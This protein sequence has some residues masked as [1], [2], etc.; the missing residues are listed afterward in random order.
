M[1]R[2]NFKPCKSLL[3][4]TYP[5]WL[6]E[7]PF[8]HTFPNTI[9]FTTFLQHNNQPIQNPQLLYQG[10]I[11][12]DSATYTHLLKSSTRSGSVILGK[13][14]HTHLIK[15]SFHQCLFLQN[16]LLNMYCKC[17]EI[18]FACHLFEQMPNRDVV[19]W[20]LLISGYSL[21]GFYSK[22]V[23]MFCNAR[24][25]GVK[26][27][28][29]TYSGVLSVCGRTCDV[30][31]G[32]MIHGLIV[33]SGLGSQVFL[34]N[35]LID[36]YSKCGWMNQ[37]RFLFDNSHELDDVSWNSL[38]SSY[39]RTGL[40]EST[41]EFLVRMHRSG[42][43]LNSFALGSALKAC[44]S[45]FG[46][47]REIGKM[48]HGSA[49]NFGLDLD[50]V[51]ATA[52]LHMYAR[53]GD[54]S[55]ATN[56]FKFTP[57]RNVVMFNAMIAG[58]FQS[59]TEISK[60]LADDALRLFSE[61]QR[62]GI[63]PSSF[64]FSSILKAC[65]AV[66]AFG[67][68]KQIHA[69]VLKNNLQIDEFIGSALVDLYSLSGQISDALRCFHSTPKIDI[70]SWTSMIAGLIRNGQ[71]EHAL[72]LF[73]DMLGS[74]GKP[75]EFTMSSALSACAGLAA[76][77]SGEQ[78][79]GYATKA[80]LGHYTV[81]GNSQVCMYGKSG[82]IDAANL[83]FKEMEDRD[84]VSWSA[85]ISSHAQ[86]GSATEALSLFEMMKR[87]GVAPNHITFLG[88]LTACSHGGLVDEGLRF[89]EIMKRDYGLPPTL[90][91]CAC[92]VDLLARSGRLVESENFIKN[93]G[94][95]DDPIMWRALLS[96]CRIHG[97]TD[98]AKRVAERVI[99][100]EPQAASS[101][102]LLYNIYS[103]A[104]IELPA[105]EIRE[106]MKDRGVKKEPG[107]SWIEI[108]ST[109]HSFVAGDR[110]HPNSQVVYEKLE[111]LLEKIRKLG[112]VN[113]KAGSDSSVEEQKDRSAANYH[114]EKLAVALGIISLPKSAPIRVMKNLRICHD[115]HTTM[116]FI[117]AAEGREIIVR[118]SIRF[119]RFR[120]GS[121]SCRDYW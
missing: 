86:H 103:D 112:Y 60:E 61:M 34:T 4:I 108:G 82:D 94:F 36:M 43:A 65:N 104:G 81:V 95:E 50:T 105:T 56:V 21:V 7:S 58:L 101:Y 5:K 29:F 90:K 54:L 111:E 1:L 117:S 71:F 119:H 11:S 2:L 115:C 89:Y 76:S 48:L 75:D 63:S 42:L 30:E 45:C 35:S 87:V 107:I 16:N 70:V 109:V 116:K 68:G 79:Q 96:A 74:R 99:G 32:V 102:V 121:C 84:V 118:D 39:V 9:T 91:H 47:S 22:A 12:L 114:S 66:E 33:V 40:Y 106:L 28:K 17:G 83:A 52:L 8:L 27:D 15:T 19:S 98:T 6:S 53:T 93:S 78:I 18:G 41:V 67:Y 26:L 51:V 14:V 46:G 100:L 10:T 49:V 23:E 80:G 72:S 20:N 3:P 97:D 31:L 77:R 25:D 110:S 55:S 113:E 62:W 73:Y 85:M 92:I 24:M 69:Q 57:N 120:H 37:A 38:I 64:T 13:L 44:S 59:D 88:V